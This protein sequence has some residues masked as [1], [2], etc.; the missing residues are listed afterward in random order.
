M[1][2]TTK[3]RLSPDFCVQGFEAVSVVHKTTAVSIDIIY[4]KMYI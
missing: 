1:S 2:A 3:A 4:T